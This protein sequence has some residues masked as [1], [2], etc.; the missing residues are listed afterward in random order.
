MGTPRYE[1]YGRFWAVYD[2]KGRLVCV[3]V[4]KR[5]AR[6]V[7][8]RLPSRRRA[9]PLRQWP[10]RSQGPSHGDCT[11]TTRLTR[12]RDRKETAP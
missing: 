11:R 5:G 12:T 1:K 8:R 9:K 2:R 4:Y 10:A 6:E 3:T 7:I